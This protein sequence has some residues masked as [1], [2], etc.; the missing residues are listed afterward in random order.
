ME[1]TTPRLYKSQG[2]KVYGE[3]TRYS[4]LHERERGGRGERKRK[5]KRTKCEILH[6]EIL[7]AAGIEVEMTT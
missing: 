2:I 7:Q 4:Y 5:A 1:D 3:L 6:Q